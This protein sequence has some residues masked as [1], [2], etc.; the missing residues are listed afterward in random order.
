MKE[1]CP[2]QNVQWRKKRRGR[3]GQLLGSD[4]TLVNRCA[5]GELSGLTV[6]S[7][8][9]RPQDE[10]VKERTEEL[11]VHRH[12]LLPSKERKQKPFS[13]GVKN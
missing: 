2:A 11:E 12:M 5:D 9:Y 6:R 10:E 8:M 4:A 1:T 13:C 3:Y 7:I